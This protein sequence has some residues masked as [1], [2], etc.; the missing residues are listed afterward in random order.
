M[1]PQMIFLSALVA[2]VAL[3][4]LAYLIGKFG[5]VGVLNG[6]RRGNQQTKK[7]DKT[8]EK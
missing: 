7:Q 8:N 3:P 5:A 1:N 2:F 4:V 6:L